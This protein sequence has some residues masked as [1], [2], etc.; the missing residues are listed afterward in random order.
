ML[1]DVKCV[2]VSGKCSLVFPK[3]TQNYNKVI[4]YIFYS[5]STVGDVGFASKAAEAAS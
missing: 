1:F 2:M 4:K 5:G 3:T